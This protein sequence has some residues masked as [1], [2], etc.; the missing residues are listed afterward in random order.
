MNEK[1]ALIT[2]E[3]ENIWKNEI[4]RI[5]ETG[6][7]VSP[8]GFEVK[9]IIG[10]QFSLKNI[11]ERLILN[12]IRRM[13][14]GF[15]F[16]ELLY[17]LSGSNSVK[18]LRPY[19][20]R[21]EE[22]S[23]NGKTYRG[24][25][26]PRIFKW[27]DRSKKSFLEKN[28]GAGS[29]APKQD[30]TPGYLLEDNLANSES[31]LDTDTL[32]TRYL[33][34]DKLGVNKIYN[35]IY[36][37]Y[38]PN[39]S[40]DNSTID[41]IK[42]IINKLTKDRDSRQALLVIW[43]PAIDNTPTKDFPCTSVMQ[44]FIRENKLHMIV[45]MRSNDIIRGTTYDV[46]NFTMIQEIIANELDVEL[47]NYYHN[48]GS[49]H[50]YE[51]DYDWAKT[52]IN[53]DYK[54]YPNIISMSRMPQQKGNLDFA[55]YVW[56]LQRMLFDEKIVEAVYIQKLKEVPEYWE[57]IGKI[58]LFYYYRDRKHINLM[59]LVNNCLPE[60]YKIFLNRT[61]KFYGVKE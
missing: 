56:Q 28:I 31:L 39:I 52:I 12:P 55:R 10:N 60:E 2:G 9:E 18:E 40:T 47:G 16:A 45:Y 14:L 58:F 49:I 38:R 36:P 7:T 20:A 54:Y 26:G 17:I 53:S 27:Q 5:L 57:N 19:N 46:F 48:T 32:D 15:A 44:F 8:R 41:Q 4:K 30:Y 3:F 11:T 43:D 25:Y 59:K 51:T 24:A 42:S 33:D 50:L 23:D 29:R 35:N 1:K 21:L 6:Y 37:K 22:F 13:N 61:L 34:T